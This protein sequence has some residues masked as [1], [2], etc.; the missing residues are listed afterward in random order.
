MVNKNLIYII[1]VCFLFFDCE[2]KTETM[3][4][5]KNNSELTKEELEMTLEEFEKKQMEDIRKESESVQ[6]EIAKKNQFPFS[7]EKNGIKKDR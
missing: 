4:I 5:K 3:K 6:K 7:S 2:N 1:S